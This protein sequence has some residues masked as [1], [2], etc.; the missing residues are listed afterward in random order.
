MSRPPRINATIDRLVLRGFAPSQRDAIAAALA[1]ELQYQLKLP[2]THA[3][4]SSRSEA[5]MKGGSIASQPH[6]SRI[7]RE[8][9][10]H[11]AVGLHGSK[12]NGN[13]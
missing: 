11:I 13:G 12:G 2:S 6:P 10:R 8:A 4:L 9:A 3:L 1:A 5:V 7:G